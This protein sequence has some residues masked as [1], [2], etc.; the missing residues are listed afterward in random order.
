MLQTAAKSRFQQSGIVK[1]H[2]A[3]KDIMMMLLSK[4][5]PSEY[6]LRAYLDNGMVITK[7][8]NGQWLLMASW[9]PK[10]MAF[11]EVEHLCEYLAS[12]F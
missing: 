9:P 6:G 7:I 12:Q 1:G 10:H 2:D 8:S 3:E 11:N 5:E 4:L